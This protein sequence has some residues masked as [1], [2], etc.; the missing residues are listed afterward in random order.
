M[1]SY[2]LLTPRLRSEQ[3]SDVFSTDAMV[4]SLP[5]GDQGYVPSSMKPADEGNPKS[6]S[7]S[8][9]G[10]QVKV[11]NSSAR[12]DAFSRLAAA[13]TTNGSNG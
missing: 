5:W 11:H 12:E 6:E 8:P 10:E 3:S 4:R 9:D 13:L 7:R 1:Q 2:G